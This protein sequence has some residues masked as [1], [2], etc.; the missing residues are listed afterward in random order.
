MGART[1]RRIAAEDFTRELAAHNPIVTKSG[2]VF[3]HVPRG[4]YVA[5]ANG[6][7][8]HARNA[9]RGESRDLDERMER[10]EFVEILRVV[11]LFC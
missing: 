8:R 9:R 7:A 4:G 1:G 5:K 10:C 11:R 6:C 3:L 2:P